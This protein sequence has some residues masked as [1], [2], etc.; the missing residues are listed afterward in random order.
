[1]IRTWQLLRGGNIKEKPGFREI[2]KCNF[3]VFTLLWDGFNF[4]Q[5]GHFSYPV[6]CKERV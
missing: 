5:K 1:M 3:Y 4:N 2:N 6:K